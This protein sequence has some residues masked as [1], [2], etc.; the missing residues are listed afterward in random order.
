MED[1]TEV[2]YIKT[3]TT[4]LD[5]TH[6]SLEGETTKLQDKICKTVF[7]FFFHQMMADTKPKIFSNANMVVG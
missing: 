5:K 6:G 1:I 2:E 3:E 7:F 4:W